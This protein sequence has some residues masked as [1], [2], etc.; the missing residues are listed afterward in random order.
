MN[1]N[2]ATT[3]IQRFIIVLFKYGGNL[4]NDIF[5][6]CSSWFLIEKNRCNFKKICHIVLDCTLISL[7]FLFIF[8]VLGYKIPKEEIIS[9]IFSVWLGHYWFIKCYL[10]FYI[11]HPVINCAI[12]NMNRS[13]HLKSILFLAPIYCGLNFLK[14]SF[15][16]SHIIVFICIYF[17]TSYMKLYMVKFCSSPKVNFAVL[18]F[19]A[20]GN[21]LLIVITNL[22]GLI[23]KANFLMHWNVIMN[24]FTILSCLALLNISVSFNFKVK[25]INYLS[26]LSL[27]I[28]LFH[29]NYLIFTYITGKYYEYIYRVYSYKYELI[30]VTLFAIGLLV[31]G[32]FLAALYNII[33]NGTLYKLCDKLFEKIKI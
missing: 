24:P 17:F 25:V 23:F 16:Y 8:L 7:L 26:S 22:M 2:L 20:S 18:F 30:W 10:L 21:F 19:S 29:N 27:L 1:L 13:M 33:E 14:E 5:I 32:I 15:Y 31:F 4:G 28:Y 9:Q 11:M 12:K 6:V 3:S